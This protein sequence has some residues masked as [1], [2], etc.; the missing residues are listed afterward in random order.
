[1]AR[2]TDSPAVAAFAA[3][4]ARLHEAH[5]GRHELAPVGASH[6]ALAS[7][8]LH[9]RLSDEHRAWLQAMGGQP[10]SPELLG[11]SAARLP[12]L[13]LDP[14]ECLSAAQV[15]EQLA[16]LRHRDEPWPAG[17]VP[18]AQQGASYVVIELD[19]PL[20]G[21]AGQLLYVRLGSDARLV[22]SPSIEAWFLDV[23][24]RI[25]AGDIALLG[26]EQ[27]PGAVVLLDLARLGQK[28][29]LDLVEDLPFLPCAATARLVHDGDVLLDHLVD[30]A[31]VELGG[32]ASPRV[33]ALAGLL[34]HCVDDDAKEDCALLLLDAADDD[35]AILEHYL[36]EEALL[37]A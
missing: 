22:I 29:G 37:R 32:V 11:M 7:L 36:D 19:P 34:G 2:P 23:A 5:P 24:D 15:E 18:F 4:D 13:V 16:L 31:L 28:K 9:T 1:M 21:T 27:E 35:P 30:E 25:E 20:G 10:S 33:R 8:Q 26:G 14:V 12:A 3:L 17:W 6:A